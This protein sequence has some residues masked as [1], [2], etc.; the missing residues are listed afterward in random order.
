MGCHP[1]QVTYIFWLMVKT[2]NQTNMALHRKVFYKCW[3]FHCHDY[4]KPYIGSFRSRSLSAKDRLR[5]IFFVS[6]LE[7]SRFETDPGCKHPPCLIEVASRHGRAQAY[8]RKPCEIF[9]PITKR[10]QT[11]GKQFRAQV[12]FLEAFSGCC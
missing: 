6:I 7:Q 11:R 5:S 1:S 10:Q 4:Q 8:M 12:F 3:I 9:A 2:T